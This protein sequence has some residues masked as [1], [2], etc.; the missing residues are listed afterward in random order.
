MIVFLSVILGKLGMLFWVFFMF[1]VVEFCFVFEVVLVLFI[2][3]V[4]FKLGR[5]KFGCFVLGLL[6]GGFVLLFGIWF[7]VCIFRD[8]FGLG[9]GF[10]NGLYR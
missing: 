3:F 6:V 10:F 7:G 2:G 1:F 5:I 8:G 9:K 4:W